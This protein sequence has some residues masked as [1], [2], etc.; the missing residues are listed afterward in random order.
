MSPP[1]GEVWWGREAES[2]GQPALA[3]GRGLAGSQPQLL[4]ASKETVRAALEARIAG[5]TPAWT[6]PAADDSGVALVKLFGIMMEPLLSRV[7]QLPDKAL[8][9]YLS[10]AGVTPLPAT[11]A[12][13]LLTFIIAPAAGASVTVP[14]GFQAG[15]SASA[16][17]SGQ[18]IF[19]TER[20]VQATPATIAAIAVGVNGVVSAVD[21][22]LAGFR[23]FGPESTPG[24]ALWIGLSLPPGANS[25]APSLSLALVPAV[26]PGTPPP[27]V[28]AGGV[29][30]PAAAPA[31]LVDWAILDGGTVVPATLLRDET[32]GLSSGGVVELGVPAQWRPGNPPGSFGLPALLWLRAML[33]HGQYPS[34]PVFSAVLLNVARA[35][36]SRTIRDEPLVQM[37]DST[38][39]LTRMQLSQ[40]PIVPHSVQID[41]DADP[42]GDVFGTT[43]GTTT[44]W[45]EVGNLG[46]SGP[47]AQVFTVDYATGVVTFGD[48][49]TG[50]RPPSGLRNVRATEYRAGGGVAGAVAADAVNAP[51]TSVGFVTTVSNPAPASGGTDVEPDSR[52]IMRGAQELRTGGRAV[53]PADYGVLAVNAPGALVARAQGVAGLHPDYPGAPVPGVVGV[54]CVAPDAGTGQPPVPGEDDLR[55]V[56]VFL[57]GQAAP[58]GV[59]V[60]AAA[61]SFHP[62]T[63]ESWLVLDPSRDQAD[64]L[65]AAGTALSAYLHPLSGGDAGTGWPFGGP[66]QHAALVRCLLQVPGVRAVS[67]LS[68]MLDGV[69][70]PP[71]TNVPIPPN[72]LP[73]PGDHHLLPV[74]GAGT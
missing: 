62:V 9:E 2:R 69:R 41:V 44:P 8:V 63:V 24:D 29:P 37:P 1:S 46:G 49:V 58:A 31:P 39:G 28:T 40:T 13:A 35:P 54:L 22:A 33:T 70:Y 11:A 55:A 42:G 57:S 56:T 71:C 48:G 14:A 47:A 67:Q 18:V 5:F 27:P 53:T 10:I 36:A 6:N 66:L 17:N 30:P 12:E 34:P 60:A 73:W 4:A 21:P 26:T 72:T 19:E 65:R 74:P 59:L 45:T 20:A 23:V 32:G 50:A 16:G 3:D 52:A 61:A 68:V 64:L 7:N 38:E 25:P 51:L 43:P 15:A